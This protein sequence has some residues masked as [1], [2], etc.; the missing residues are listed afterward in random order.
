MVAAW[1][2]LAAVGMA[3]AIPSAPGFFGT[4]HAACKVA[5]EPFGV[6]SETAVAVGT[7]LHATFWSTLTLLGL[8][9]LRGRST[10]L[11][12]LAPDSE[13]P[14]SPDPDSKAQ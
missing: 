7:L 6:D 13:S 9:V 1:I 14:E 8:L 5:L 11:G 2:T 3:V 10:S 4:Y 12:E